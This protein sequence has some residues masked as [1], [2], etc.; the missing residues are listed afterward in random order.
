MK[1]TRLFRTQVVA[2]VCIGLLVSQSVVLAGSM[3]RPLTA[4]VSLAA[5]GLLVGQV[6][7]QQGVGIPN[8]RVLVRQQDRDLVGTA[9]DKSGRFAVSGLRSGT[10]QLL[11]ANGQSTVRVWTA[12]TA[13]PVAKPSV[14]IV[15]GSQQ[16]IRA[17]FGNGG[18][19]PW[20]LPALAA[21]GIITGVAVATSN[22]SS[23]PSSP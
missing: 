22:N 11:A 1:G 17:Q 13:P 21:G 15:S 19:G 4:D 8:A 14:M 7:D 2:L 3:N 9:T 10:Y 12:N 20:V 5:H 23:T 18:I 6:V 16:V